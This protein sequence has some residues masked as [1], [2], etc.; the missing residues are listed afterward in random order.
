MASISTAVE[1]T[2]RMTYPLNS[3]AS[4]MGNVIEI[5]GNMNT[6]MNEAFD[7]SKINS[8][9]I[10][11]DAAKAS[12]SAITEQFNNA[13]NGANN[14]GNNINNV[15]NKQE[16]LNRKL[17][18]GTTASNSFIK[19]LMGF[20]VIQKIIGLVS[21]QVGNAI[22]R[23]DTMNNY[24]K[25][26]SN[27]GISSDQSNAS[28][29]MLSENLK[30]LPTTL[31]DAV[32]SVQNFTS[33]NGSVGKSTKMFLA[34]NNAILAGGGTTQVQ[35]SAL[36][37]LS[38]AYAK[39]KPDMMEW[40]TA[41]TAMP[42]QLKQVAQAMGYVNTSELGEALRSG[43]ES[44][45]DFMDTFIQL[46]E[47]GV[48]GFQSFEDQARNATGGFATTIANMKSAVTRGIGNMIT[49]INTALESAGLGTIQE[50]ILGIGANFEVLFTN[51]GNLVAN[52]V[53]LLQ[54]IISVAQRIGQGISDNWSIISPILY[55]LI[56]VLAIYATY[57]GIA[58][59]ATKAWS[60]VQ[61][62]FNG[63]MSMNP[64]ML[65]V[66]GIIALIAVIFA[67]I[68][69][70]NKWKG[71][72]ISAVGAICGAIN[73][74]IQFFWN[75]LQT[76][77]NI[78]LGIWNALGACA[79][80]IGIAFKNVISNI[81]SW[82][83][84]LLETVTNVITSI[85]NIL[86][87][88]PFINIDTTGLTSK[89]QEY[90]NKKADAENSKEAYKSVS[91]AFDEGMSTF[92]TW[93]DG[94]AANAYNAGYDF[95]SGLQDDIGNMFSNGLN[96]NGISDNLGLNLDSSLANI[97]GNT[98]DTASNT[99]KINDV[100]SS[101]E[102]D[103]KYLRDLAESEVI[104]R[105]TTNKIKIEMGGIT[106]NINKESDLDGV[107]DYLTNGV[108]EAMEQAAEGVHE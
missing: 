72:N 60:A 2:D 9:R 1:L 54:P 40:R 64:V 11:I 45:D 50:I 12:I 36:E 103:L 27:L 37:Q 21:S 82:F 48:N 38:Q 89:A 69:A 62:V 32:S 39:G 7:D 35:Q 55:G 98:A 91:A 107:V 52:I 16:Q 10:S 26:M 20:S 66:L 74:V 99:G 22:D 13:R 78:A 30:G 61:A 56:A 6:S 19:S 95:G 14:F 43:K 102:E 53:T 87:K 47:K 68:G 41:M 70:I 75:L 88:I 59:M 84:G 58:T 85:V 18:E 5:M 3:I 24:P 81:K 44:M 8:A 105:Y 101:T 92:E 71:T 46:N 17:Q 25:V 67:V 73:V 97:A 49:S 34:L 65:I 42:A 4:A 33:V 108:N 79:D 63:I 93:Q 83:Y 86:N 15:A 96:I 51:I 28:I 31:N 23:L 94:W 90:A 29:K 76:V 77:A 80:N 106:N 57:T 100:L 104:N